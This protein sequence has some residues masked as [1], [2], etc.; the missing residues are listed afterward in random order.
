M[1]QADEVPLV[2]MAH[3]QQSRMEEIESLVEITDGPELQ[4]L[5]QSHFH[6]SVRAVIAE[7]E[8]RN[9]ELQ[10]IYDRVVLK[11]IGRD[12]G[13]GDMDPKWLDAWENQDEITKYNACKSELE[14]LKS[15]TEDLRAMNVKIRQRIEFEKKKLLHS[16]K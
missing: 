8:A 13:L 16:R 10:A 5:A 11:A 7:L 1:E 12:R 14:F 9:R 4:R 15:R 6:P 3:F 2:F